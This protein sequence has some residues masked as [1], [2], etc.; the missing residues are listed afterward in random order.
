MHESID[1]S[2]LCDV[3]LYEGR[4][5]TPSGV[6][7][8]TTDGKNSQ[9]YLQGGSIAAGRPASA[10][11][12]ITRSHKLVRLV[13]KGMMSYHAGV[14]RWKGKIDQGNLVSRELVGVEI[15]NYDREGEIPTVEQH[16]C[17]AAFLLAYAFHYP[18]QALMVYGHY[19]LAWPMGRRSD[20]HALDW[21]YVFWAMAHNPDACKLRGA[22][23]F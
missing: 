7:L 3:R 2:A 1:A 21:G 12:L 6:L 23:P 18:T 11:F 5:G 22:Q 17:V 9:A 10:D 20:P 14:C 19:G 15:E 16:L 8:H 4:N 13:P